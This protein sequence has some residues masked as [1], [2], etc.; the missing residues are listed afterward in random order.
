MA[1]DSWN[2]LKAAAAG[3]RSSGWFS[4]AD[5][6]AHFAPDTSSKLRSLVVVHFENRVAFAESLTANEGEPS[7]QIVIPSDS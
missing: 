4:T 3:E 6:G 5:D 7:Q 2:V 1:P